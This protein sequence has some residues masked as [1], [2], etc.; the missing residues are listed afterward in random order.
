LFL[1]PISSHVEERAQRAAS[2]KIAE[3]DTIVTTNP[4]KRDSHAAQREPL[5]LLACPT[6]KDIYFYDF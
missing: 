3:N 1:Q 6:M 2:W 4:K 5:A